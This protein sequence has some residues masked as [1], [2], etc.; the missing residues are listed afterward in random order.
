VLSLLVGGF[1]GLLAFVVVTAAVAAAVGEIARGERPGPL[2]AL[3]QVRLRLAD[4]ALGLGRAFLIVLLLD[5]TVVLI[6]FGIHRL[7]RYQLFAPVVML[8]GRGPRAA[9]A[10]SSLL[11][12]G[13]WW[14]T[15]IVVTLIHGTLAVAGLAVGLVL[16]L[17]LTSLPLWLLSSLV[18]LVSALFMPLG[19]IALTLL[20]GDAAAEHDAREALLLAQAEGVNTTGM[21][22]GPE[23]KL[24]AR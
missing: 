4:L 8:E 7:V 19:A 6:P 9:L 12:K 3:R 10:R 14:N 1:A 23:M 16:L 20:Y 18:T 11:V 2:H 17:V 5:L 21:D 24:D 13:R 22:S 15:A